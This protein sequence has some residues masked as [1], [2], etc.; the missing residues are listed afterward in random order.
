MKLTK[1]LR[2][3]DRV[4]D[5][6]LAKSMDE[7]NEGGELKPGDIVDQ[8][9]ADKPTKSEDE[10]E[11]KKEQSEAED[12]DEV[13]QYE[14]TEGAS[15]TEE[16]EVRDEPESTED[17]TDEDSDE[18]TETTEPEDE[19]VDSS[20]PEVAGDS[21]EDTSL[22][23][24]D[25]DSDE[26]EDSDE[27]EPKEVAKSIRSEFTDNDTIAKGVKSSEF[28]SAMVDVV[29]KSM[30]DVQF[31]LLHQGHVSEG[32]TDVL[33]KS[34]SAVIM[35]NQALKSDNDRL[36]RRVNR[37]EKSIKRGFDR[38]MDSLDEIS[39]Q[40]AGL[41]KSVA[42]I[43]VHDRSFAKSLNG[44]VDQGGFES[45]SKSQVLTTL[46]NEL[47]AGNASVSPQ[48]IVAFESGAPLRSDL[49]A[50]VVSKCNVR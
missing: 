33:A 41:R 8:T 4:A 17:D 26:Y 10:D 27:D 11:D 42:S 29:A 1:S 2:D 47:Y 36:T 9:D 31:D 13:G 45:L 21:D 15:T 39:V 23:E 37:L 46:N 38:V 3:L 16:P 49:Q 48:D 50:L 43:D 19:D 32:A 22:D 35:S 24:T 28:L 14:G 18:D 7:D 12:G 34:L 44:S 25:E 5:E 40:P 6:L 20:E 30:A